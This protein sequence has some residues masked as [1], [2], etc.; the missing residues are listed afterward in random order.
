MNKFSLS[1]CLSALL[2]APFTPASA[3]QVIIAGSLTLAGYRASCGPVETVVMEM[4]DI[5]EARNGRIFL[6]K[7][8][9]SRPRAQ[10]IFW[11]THECAHHIFG[12]GE[13]R[14]DCWA[15]QQGRSHGWLAPD[16]FNL[17]GRSMISHP[18]TAAHA[19]G[20]QRVAAM[21]S[22]YNRDIYAA[23]E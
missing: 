22:C 20:P 18:G 17:L 21:R 10:Q 15:V 7:S 3:Q 5:A 9:M 2:L 8:L 1:A 16:E 6:N 13:A 14:A 12:A 19:P 23:A 4:Y 11:Y